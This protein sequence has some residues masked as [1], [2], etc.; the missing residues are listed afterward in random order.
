MA[1][2]IEILSL[3][4]GKAVEDLVGGGTDVLQA[5][6]PFFEVEVRQAI[7]KQFQAH[8]GAEFLILPQ[9]A[10][11]PISAENMAAMFDPFQGGVQL[12]FEITAEAMTKDLADRIGGKAVE[13][14]LTTTFKEVPDRKV[15]FEDDIR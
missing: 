8:E 7:A 1:V 15:L 14:Q 10:A 5:G 9:T 12:A 4:G 6:Q 11:L 2:G 13:A 3:V